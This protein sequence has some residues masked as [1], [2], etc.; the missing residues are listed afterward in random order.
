[1]EVCAQPAAFQRTTMSMD[2]IQTLCGC[3]RFLLK[4]GTLGSHCR[5]DETMCGK[6]SGIPGSE[7]AMA[8]V[9]VRCKVDGAIGRTSR[10]QREML[11]MDPTTMTPMTVEVLPRVDG[12]TAM[13]KEV[14]TE[15]VTARAAA[16]EKRGV[17]W[18][19]M[20][21]G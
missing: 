5:T 13:A 10:P 20:E 7:A 1:M 3:D 12:G 6:R 21:A 18:V 8:A 9:Q 15:E 4:A 11:G 19:V 2:V 17:G 14:W 16:K